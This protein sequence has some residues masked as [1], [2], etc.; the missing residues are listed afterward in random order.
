MGESQS[1]FNKKE[2]TAGDETN[3]AEDT[4]RSLSEMP[5]EI[6]A[7]YKNIQTLKALTDKNTFKR[8]MMNM[9][10]AEN[11][12]MVDTKTNQ[13]TGQARVFR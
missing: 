11:I 8:E 7:E 3:R 4:K 12:K 5:N 9:Q 13:A 2:G 6:K 1:N 10:L